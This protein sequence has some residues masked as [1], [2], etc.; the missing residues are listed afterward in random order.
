MSMT[1][2]EL[3]EYLLRVERETEDSL[4]QVRA[5]R[6][7]WEQDLKKDEERFFENYCNLTDET[8]LGLCAKVWE[9]VKENDRNHGRLADTD[10][11]GLVWIV[12]KAEYEQT[13][14]N[15]DC[16]DRL[17]GQIVDYRLSLRL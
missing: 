5:L 16:L 11:E 4:E 3:R 7:V 8:L 13:P 12:T 1:N 2:Y 15:G 17:W 6:K 10:Y 14:M 9:Y